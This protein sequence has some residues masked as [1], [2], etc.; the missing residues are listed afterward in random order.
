MNEWINRRD[1]FSKNSCAESTNQTFHTSSSSCY[2]T[3]I[4]RY[5]TTWHHY[6]I[7]YFIFTITYQQDYTPS[8]KTDGKMLHT[9]IYIDLLIDDAVWMTYTNGTVST[10]VWNA[11]WLADGTVLLVQLRYVI[12]VGASRVVSSEWS[13]GLSSYWLDYLYSLKIMQTDRKRYG[14]QVPVSN[15]ST[16][17]LAFLNVIIVSMTE[18]AIRYDT[19]RCDAMYE[20]VYVGIGRQGAAYDDDWI[21]VRVHTSK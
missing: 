18:D 3:V 7:Q 20:P 13:S 5:C 10:R 2:S 15:T 9:T 19:M 16:C 6:N 14:I 4:I 12:V 8:P 17:L 21:D 1:D 11:D